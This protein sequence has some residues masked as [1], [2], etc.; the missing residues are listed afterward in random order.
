MG[1]E[2]KKY[3]HKLVKEN[4]GYVFMFYQF[5]L[6]PDVYLGGES[7]ETIKDYYNYGYI[8]ELLVSYKKFEFMILCLSDEDFRR[9]IDGRINL[10]R[11]MRFMAYD[12]REY[13]NKHREVFNNESFINMLYGKEKIG[14][15]REKYNILT[16]LS[17]KDYYDKFGWMYNISL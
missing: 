3:L 12:F 13:R 11:K 9:R 2:I 4:N 16:L 8:K 5:Y 10:V 7:E 1:E 14:E 15:W 6:H 17:Y